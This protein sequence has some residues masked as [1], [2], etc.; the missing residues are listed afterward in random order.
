VF[1]DTGFREVLKRIEVYD[2]PSRRMIYSFDARKQKV[3]DVS[4]VA[5][6]PDG[7]LLAVLTDG[8]VLVYRIPSSPPTS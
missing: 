4:G 3:K 8:V 1:F 7:S 5:L 2:I 6:S